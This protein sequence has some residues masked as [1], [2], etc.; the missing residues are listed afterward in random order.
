MSLEIKTHLQNLSNEMGC[1]EPEFSYLAAKIRTDTSDEDLKQI[2]LQ[3]IQ[4]CSTVKFLKLLHV[5]IRT[6]KR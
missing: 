2:L 1:V 4:R 6:K 5:P 3:G